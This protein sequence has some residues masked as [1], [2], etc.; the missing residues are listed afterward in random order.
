MAEAQLCWP[1]LGPAAGRLSALL[2][3]LCPAGSMG[4]TPPVACSRRLAS[5]CWQLLLCLAVVAAATKQEALCTADIQ[6]GRGKSPGVAAGLLRAVADSKLRG[7][8]VA[9]CLWQQGM[10]QRGQGV[11]DVVSSH[12]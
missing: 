8:Q 7:E 10:C 1:L 4:R 12:R 3:W 5:V 6:V 2:L 11:L 9:L